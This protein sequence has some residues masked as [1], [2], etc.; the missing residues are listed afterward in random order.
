MDYPVEQM[1]AQ[2]L[3]RGHR[4]YMQPVHDPVNAV[5]LQASLAN[6]DSVM[7]GGNG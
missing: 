2:T 6:I 3:I 4:R 7:V 1:T 5:L